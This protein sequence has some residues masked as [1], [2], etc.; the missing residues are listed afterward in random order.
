MYIVETFVE[1]VK[2]CGKY[3]Y[4]WKTFKKAVIIKVRLHMHPVYPCK[5]D[6]RYFKRKTN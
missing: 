2:I 4:F 6:S 1:Y 5:M 3:W